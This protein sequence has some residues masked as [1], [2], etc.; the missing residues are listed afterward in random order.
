M[1]SGT[2]GVLSGYTFWYYLR[3]L[4]LSECTFGGDTLLLGSTPVSI[5]FGALLGI[6]GIKCQV[7]EGRCLGNSL[8]SSGEHSP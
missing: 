4:I 1:H 7:P 5:P 2:T 3:A 8:R 6:T